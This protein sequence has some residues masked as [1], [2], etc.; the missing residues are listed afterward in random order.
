MILPSALSPLLGTSAFVG[1]AALL[2]VLIVG[3]ALHSVSYISV[4]VASGLAIVGAAVAIYSAASAIAEVG[5]TPAYDARVGFGWAALALGGLAGA[6][7][8]TPFRRPI[9]VALVIVVAG[10]LGCVAINLL[11]TNTWYLGAMLLWLGAA[12]LRVSSAR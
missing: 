12:V 8:A 11:F 6:A 4:G 10:L 9:A 5:R 1:S 2:L 7:G 3:R